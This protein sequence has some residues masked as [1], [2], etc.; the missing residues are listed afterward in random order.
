[1]N[2]YPKEKINVLLLENIHENALNLFKN[3][4]FKVELL[5]EAFEE[6]ELAE[7]IKDVHILGIRSKT[8]V[9]KKALEHANKLLSIGC[10]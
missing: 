9:T 7:R 4:G 8:N 10:F 2:S 1:M 5:K 6:S 3:D